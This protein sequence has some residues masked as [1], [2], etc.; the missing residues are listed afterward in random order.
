M[1]P[2][3]GGASAVPDWPADL[4]PPPFADVLHGKN[5]LPVNKLRPGLLKPDDGFMGHGDYRAHFFDNRSTFELLR[6][7]VADKVRYSTYR[8][9]HQQVLVE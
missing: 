8:V 5:H 2:T 1:N 7:F 4:L 6:K 9:T 3:P